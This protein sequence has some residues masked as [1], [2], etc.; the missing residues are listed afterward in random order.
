MALLTLIP[1]L[2]PDHYVNQPV[3]AQLDAF[4]PGFQPTQ[5]TKKGPGEAK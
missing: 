4:R 2:P 1:G 3:K 5:D